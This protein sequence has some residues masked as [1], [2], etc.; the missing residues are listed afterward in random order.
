[1]SFISELPNTCRSNIPV[2]T[3][4]S[5]DGKDF[6]IWKEIEIPSLLALLK[7]KDK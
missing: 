3:Q 2:P 6:T 5:E 1:M 4:A 7:N